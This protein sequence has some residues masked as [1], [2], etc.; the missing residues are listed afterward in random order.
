MDFTLTP[1]EEEKFKHLDTLVVNKTYRYDPN[2][3]DISEFMECLDKYSAT[4]FNCL[5]ID[6]EKHTFKRTWT[7]AVI[8]R[9]KEFGIEL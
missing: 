3:S 8:S 5:Q 7:D 6:N 2:R 4:W 1:Y 9:C